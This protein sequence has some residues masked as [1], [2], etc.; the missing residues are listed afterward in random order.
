MSNPPTN[1]GRQI[2]LNFPPITE[3]RTANTSTSP[4]KR[5][6]ADTAGNTLPTLPRNPT[7]Y[8]PPLARTT[9]FFFKDK[10]PLYTRH[11]VEGSSSTM[12]IRCA[13]AGCNTLGY[14]E[15]PRL[16]SG[17]TNL[18]THYRNNHPTFATSK[19][20][21]KEQQKQLGIKPPVIALFNKP[22]AD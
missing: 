3:Q 22:V 16:L 13:Q 10:N 19:K 2:G 17:T 1:R 4:S 18:K 9:S 7:L 15:I 14:R 6:R 20:E 11:I 5:A 12:E 8:T 21:W